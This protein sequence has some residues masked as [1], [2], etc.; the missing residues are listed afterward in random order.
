MRSPAESVSH[1]ID[2]N[3]NPGTHQ[4]P[5]HRLDGNRLAGGSDAVDQLAAAELPKSFGRD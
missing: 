2:P 4:T 3:R 1:P 5:L